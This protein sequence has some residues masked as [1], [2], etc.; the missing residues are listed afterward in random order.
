MKRKLKNNKENIRFQKERFMRNHRKSARTVHKIQLKEK[1]NNK[2][3]SKLTKFPKSSSQPLLQQFD[4]NHIL[5][6]KSPEA[7][8]L[9]NIVDKLNTL[10]GD[11]ENAAR[12]ESNTKLHMLSVNNIKTILNNK[13]RADS[14]SLNNWPNYDATLPPLERK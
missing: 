4:G 12:P 9:Y 2:N 13:L 3:K 11:K 10:E 8:A 5:T 7:K 6:M 1:E 14:I